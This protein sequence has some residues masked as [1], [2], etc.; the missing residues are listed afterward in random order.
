MF[1]KTNINN[2]THKE[3]QISNA[4]DSG[5]NLFFKDQFLKIYALHTAKIQGTFR[6]NHIAKDHAACYHISGKIQLRFEV[7]N[8]M[9]VKSFHVRW[10]LSSNLTRLPVQQNIVGFSPSDS[11]HVV[12]QLHPPLRPISSP[13]GIKET[14]F[15]FLIHIS[16]L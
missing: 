14:S 11:S 2:S 13:R 3:N 12:D 5:N 1:R 15:N 8:R 7:I 9:P 4:T 10:I 6:V 16:R